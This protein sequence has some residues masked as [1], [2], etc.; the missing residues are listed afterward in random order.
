MP[1]VSRHELREHTEAA[2][3]SGGARR[4]DLIMAAINSSARQEVVDTLLGAHRGSLRDDR[5][6]LAT[7]VQ[8]GPEMSP[9]SGGTLRSTA[10]DSVTL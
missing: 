3:A 4:S 10:A 7:I 2:F 9:T 6:G 8:G 5:R 1:L